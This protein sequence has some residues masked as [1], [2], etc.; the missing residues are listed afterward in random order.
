MSVLLSVRTAAADL[1]AALEAS[2][3]GKG[4]AD[5]HQDNGALIVHLAACLD[6]THAADAVAKPATAACH[7]LEHFKLFWCFDVSKS[8]CQIIPCCHNITKSEC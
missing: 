3:T 8:C 4:S 5:L 1:W 2:K 6:E 7:L